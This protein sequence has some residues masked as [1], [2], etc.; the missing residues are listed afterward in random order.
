MWKVSE[1]A[2]IQR[3]HDLA[4]KWCKLALHSVFSG[5]SES[6]LT[7][8]LRRIIYYSIETG[9]YDEARMTFDTMDQAGKDNPHTRYLAF[10]LA[11][12]IGDTVLGIQI[13]Q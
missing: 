9:N 6:N 2:N 13:K 10:K 11:I 7:K 1:A 8:I 3:N 5:A 4:L 12:R